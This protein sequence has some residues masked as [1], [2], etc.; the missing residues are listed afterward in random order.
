L[1]S[2]KGQRDYAKQ[3]QIPHFGSSE[4]AKEEVTDKLTVETLELPG[5]KERSS[6]GTSVKRS[7]NSII[8]AKAD[9][10]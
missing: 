5:K 4:N 2:E 6:D 9:Y 1:H 3:A 10:E 7:T 8:I